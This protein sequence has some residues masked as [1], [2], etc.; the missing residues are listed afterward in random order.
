VTEHTDSDL[1][2]TY[3][4][5]RLEPA[6]TE[7]VRRHVDFVYSA[8]IRMVRDPHLAEDVTQ[9]VFIALAKQASDLTERASLVGWLHRTA[10]NIAAQ[11][12]RTIER[13]RAREQEAVNMNELISSLPEASWE[14][15]EQHLDA[16]LGEL[17]D[18]DRDA[19]LLRYFQKKSADEMAQILGISGEAAQ[20][21]LN[22]AVEKLRE[23]FTKRKITVGAGVLTTL[24]SANA[25]QSAPVGLAAT[26]SAATIA[27]TAVTTSTMVAATTKIIAMTTLQKTLVTVA[28]ATAFAGT[29][30]YAARENAQLRGQVQTLLQQ[31]A[32]MAEQIQELQNSFAD[33]TNQLAGL[34]VENAKLKSNSNGRELLKL[35]GEVTQLRT[36]TAQ[37]DSHDPT[38]EAA[39]GVAATVKQ[40]KQWLEQ[41]PNEKIPEFQYLTA[42]EWLRGAS[43]C[44]EWKTDDDFA[45]GLSQLRRDAKRTFANAIG[46]ALANYVAGNNGQLPGDISQLESYFNPPIDGT[47]LQRYKL[48]QTGNLR[49][50]PNNEPLIAE[51]APVDDR[52]DSLFKISATGYSYQGTG[53]SA[54]VT[55][56]GKGD[57]GKATK[58]KIKPFER[59]LVKN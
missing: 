34:L 47:V 5:Q 44:P 59:P 23:F 29:G 53:K 6:F 1:L 56:S 31:Q 48:L 20:K 51:Q 40:M 28:V 55:G 32:P 37:N 10:Q 17:S 26:I 43:Y 7:L 25:V 33:A 38:D 15:I 50:L 49:D 52:Y 36:A 2:R 58:A 19:V 11:T 39:K 27:G 30:I 21:R 46:D 12:V 57:F 3:A 45:Q 8:A 35:R 16:A 13:R 4:E 42:Q 9:G 22:R 18:S 14:Q 24:I 54:W 41:N